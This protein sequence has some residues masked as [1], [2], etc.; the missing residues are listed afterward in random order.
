M[1]IAAIL[2]NRPTARLALVFLAML[3]GAVVLAGFLAPYPFAEQHRESPFAPPT[4]I[5]FFDAAGHFHPRPL[6]YGPEGSQTYPIELFVHGRLFGVQEPG[7]LFLLGSDGF[8]R[9][10]FSRLLYGGQVSLLTGLAAAFLSLGLGWVLGTAAGFYGGWLDRLL[11]RS[12]ELFL[13]L[14]WLYLLLAVRGFLP[15]HIT[16]LQAF[17][18]LIVVIGAIGWVRPARLVRGV[19]LSGKERPFVL[20]AQGFGAT[21]AY[22]MR[23]HIL[24]LTAGVIL[25][26]ATVL[27]PQYI[28]AEVT[29]SF[30]GLGVGEPVP[31]WGNMLSEARQYYTLVSHPWMLTPGLAAIP[32]LLAY[33]VLA[34]ALLPDQRYRYP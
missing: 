25:T 24:P 30:L 29:L 12:G 34:D 14:P 10:V 21:D 2:E 8:G 22:L 5:H 32:V 28:L 1:K 4:R 13:V 7:V 17:L 23:R 11:M 6:V 31:S 9:D 33:L 20:A 3:H 15:L 19:V 16:A 26:Q 27:I 18:L